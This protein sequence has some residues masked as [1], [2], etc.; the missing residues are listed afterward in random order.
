MCPTGPIVTK[1]N[2]LWKLWLW[3]FEI[4]YFLKMSTFTTKPLAQ[5]SVTDEE[6]AEWKDQFT[7]VRRNFLLDHMYVG[8]S[9]FAFSGLLEIPYFISSCLKIFVSSVN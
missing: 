3:K 8:I 2:L 4:L 1:K 6:K 5:V 9:N 7:A